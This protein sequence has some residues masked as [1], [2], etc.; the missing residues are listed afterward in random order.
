MWWVARDCRYVNW[1]LFETSATRARCSVRLIL[2]APAPG[3]F[4]SIRPHSACRSWKICAMSL[5]LTINL[6]AKKLHKHLH[7]FDENLGA[8]CHLALRQ[9]ET[10]PFESQRRDFCNRCP[11]D[12]IYLVRHKNGCSDRVRAKSKM[13]YINRAVKQFATCAAQ[14]KFFKVRA[15]FVVSRHIHI[16]LIGKSRKRAKKSIHLW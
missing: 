5:L 15:L 9:L 8:N 3:A 12:Y 16:L 14:G 7:W 10:S 6:T 2:P 13:W 1:Y 11:F 4:R